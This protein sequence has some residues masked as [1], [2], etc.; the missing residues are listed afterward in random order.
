MPSVD[1]L[2]L[3]AVSRCLRQRCIAGDKRRVNRLRE[4]HVHR[5]IGRDV[6]SEFPPTREEVQMGVA[7]E[8]E[9]GEIHDRLGRAVSRE[10]AHPYKSPET[11]GDFNVHQMGG[12]QLVP[13]SK[14]PGLNPDAKRCLQKKLQKGRRVENDHADSRSSRIMTAAGVFKVTRFRRWIRAS[15]SSRVGRAASRS[16]SVSR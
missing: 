14:D 3:R 5:V 9:V 6:L 1:H 7:M 16:S 13:I 10:L 2:D 15:I 4:R 12:V 8:V 11:L